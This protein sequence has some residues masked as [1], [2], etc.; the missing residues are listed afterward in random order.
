MDLSRYPHI[1]SYCRPAPPREIHAYKQ[2]R[3]HLA[4]KKSGAA[5][6]DDGAGSRKLRTPE[7][8][9]PPLSSRMLPLIWGA[10]FRFQPMNGWKPKTRTKTKINTS[11]AHINQHQC[12]SG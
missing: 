3:K 7:I 6:D 11:Y 8:I 2:D 12:R 10:T 5:C 9:G 1:G 4:R